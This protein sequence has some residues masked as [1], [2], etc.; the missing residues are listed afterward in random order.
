MLENI[1]NRF[2]WLESE[3]AGMELW[4]WIVLPVTLIGAW[5]VTHLLVAL[6]MKIVRRLTR[7]KV[8]FDNYIGSVSAPVG[9]FLTSLAFVTAQNLLPLDTNIAGKLSFFNKALFTYAFAWGFIRITHNLFEI[10]H[11]RLL[12]KHR[13]SAAAMMPLMRKISK[14]AIV[15]LAL[16]FLLQN[17]GF[18]VAAIIAAL[19][20]GGIAVALA[21]QKSMENLFGGVMISLD[22]PIRVG[23]FGN[24][25]NF[26]GTVEDIGLRSTRIRTLGR[27]TISIPNAEMASMRLETFS[28]REK[29]LLQTVLGLRFET[30]ST[31]MREIITKIHELLKSHPKVAENPRARFIAFKES[32]LDVELFAYI[33]TSDWD[34]YLQIQEELFLEIKDIIDSTGSGLAYPSRNVFIEKTGR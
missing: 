28:T 30:S 34:E 10:T 5:M 20:V 12:L 6:V 14:A 11:S 32:S 31:Q 33:N 17:W 3:L 19:G 25:G 4:L 16:L 22:Q 23:D 24:F 1:I 21:S 8:F 13:S 15:I 7:D 29:I 26:V 18:D 9:L 27:T 2:S